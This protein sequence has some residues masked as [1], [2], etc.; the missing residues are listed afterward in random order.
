MEACDE[1]ITARYGP[2]SAANTWQRF[3]VPLTAATFN[4][5]SATFQKV[6]SRV[7]LFRISTEMSDR[8]DVGG[9]DNV[10]VG[11]RYA[12]GYDSGPAGWSGGGD[13]TMAWK[14]TGGNPGGYLQ[15]SDWATG[16]W[17]WMVA[18]VSWAGDWRDLIG[19][20]IGFDVKTDYPD[21]VTF[22]ELSCTQ[23]KRLI[24]TADPFVMPPGG[25]SNMTVSLSES[26]AQATV[27]SLNSSAPGCITVPASVTV[28]QG[29]TSVG[30]L[31]QVTGG[32]A[33]GCEAVIRLLRP[34]MARRA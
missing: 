22:I 2:P 4:V 11:G 13:G 26:A 29:Q 19:S 14:S 1:T 34:P 12:E 31:A 16:V 18:P 24:L 28:A 5:D 33:P 30:F 27:V 17:H 20:T 8:A 15:V 21:D 32:A 25:S 3:T 6:L 23:T 10:A 7:T 9:L